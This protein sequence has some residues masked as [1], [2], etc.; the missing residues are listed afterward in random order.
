MIEGKTSR[1]FKKTKKWLWSHPSSF[2][3]LLRLLA[4]WSIA[5]LNLQIEAG[6]D[7][8]QI[9]DSWAHVLAD[10][11]FQEFSLAY[12]EYILK[13]LKKPVPVI[14]FCRGSSVFAH[15]LAHIKPAGIGLDWNCNLPALRKTVSHSIALQGNLDPDLLYAPLNKIREEAK[16]LL[17][18]MQGDP[19]FIFNLGHGLAPDVSEEAVRTLVECVQSRG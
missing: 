2:H 15:L 14:L 12:L 11:Q 17:D 3:Q 16:Q 13:G 9:F 1:D 5:Y 4:D 18:S 10:R 8:L 7:A 19:G 6:V